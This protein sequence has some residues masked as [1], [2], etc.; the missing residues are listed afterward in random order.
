MDQV[1][2]RRVDNSWA[3]LLAA[4]PLLF[5]LI[6]AGLLLSG[7]ALYGVSIVVSLVFIAAL[8]LADR[9]ALKRAGI[10]LSIGWGV[11]LMPAYLSLRSRDTDQSYGPVAAWIAALVASFAAYALLL[12]SVAQLDVSRVETFVKENANAFY[13]TAQQVDCPDRE[14]YRV[15]ARFICDVTD[16]EGVAQFTV[17][18]EDSD[19]TIRLLPPVG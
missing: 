13:G 1:E 18:V 15:G 6:D 11:F 9:A 16:T 2:S 7:Y 17:T 4:T 5:V 19:G 14:V 10:D 8:L 3:W 12:S